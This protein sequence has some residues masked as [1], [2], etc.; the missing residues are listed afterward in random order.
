MKKSVI[1]GFLGL[2][3]WST[4]LQSC[5]KDNPSPNGCNNTDSTYVDSTGNGNGENPDSTDYNGPTCGDS[6]DW[7]NNGGGIDSTDWNGGNPG[8]SLPG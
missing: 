6:T 5:N 8:D 4:T 1:L 7:N 3:L 2:C